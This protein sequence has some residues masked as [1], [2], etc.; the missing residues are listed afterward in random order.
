MSS[1]GIN[2]ILNA[3][4]KILHLKVL[5]RTTEDTELAKKYLLNL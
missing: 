5:E 2:P 3:V 4:V 1:F